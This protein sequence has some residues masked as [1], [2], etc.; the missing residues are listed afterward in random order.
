MK[1][2]LLILIIVIVLVVAI[3]KMFDDFKQSKMFTENDAQRAVAN[4]KAVYGA[5]MA[6][7]VEQIMRLETAHFNSAQYK[8]TGSAGM[9]FGKWLNIP[10]NATS[11]VKEFRDNITGQ[12]RKFIVWKSVNDFALYLASYIVRNGGN[13]ARWNSLQPAQQ[14]KYRNEVNAVKTHFV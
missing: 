2:Y 3:P 6:K 5:E 10:K 7:R 1:N 9:E 13:Y 11:G 12:V 8:Q 14:E 4:V